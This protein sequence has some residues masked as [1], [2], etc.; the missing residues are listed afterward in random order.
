MVTL[1]KV[2]KINARFGSIIEQYKNI[3]NKKVVIPFSSKDIKINENG[4][5]LI[6]KT[7]FDSHKKF[8]CTISNY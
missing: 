4:Y 2:F 3:G 1:T 8:F 6:K 5:I 7:S